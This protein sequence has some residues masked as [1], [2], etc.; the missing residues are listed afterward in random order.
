MTQPSPNPPVTPRRAPF[1]T[2]ALMSALFL[3]LLAVLAASVSTPSAWS[4]PQGAGPSSPPS[5][6]LTERRAEVSALKT[7]VSALDDQ[8]SALVEQ[9][10]QAG[11]FLS[12]AKK[13]E[14]QATFEV[15]AAKRSLAE[16][17][18]RFQNRVRQTYK[19]SPLTVLDLL[20]SSRS[21]SELVSRVRYVTG[22]LEGDRRT[23]DEVAQ[24]KSELEER[25][26]ALEAE[27]TRRETIARGIAQKRDQIEAKLAERQQDLGAARSDVA[28]KVEQQRSADLARRASARVISAA[29]QDAAQ[30]TTAADAASVTTTTTHVAR[31]TATTKQS[32]AAAP[33]TTTTAQHRTTTTAQ[34]RTSTT[35]HRKTTTTTKPTPKAVKDPAP[36]GLGDR[37]VDIGMRYLGVP[38]VWGGA[39][40]KGFDCSGLTMYVLGKVGV[41]LP[42]SSGLQFQMGTPVGRDSLRPGDLVFFGSPVHHVGI[43]VGGGEY[44]HAPYTGEVVRVSALNRSDYAGARRF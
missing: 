11:Y 32:T 43:Y 35:T 16:A 12:V 20:L 28:R 7:E 1:T 4:A 29:A 22:I 13:N 41:D 23:I 2:D 18:R 38:Y 15:V 5:V 30:E 40:T 34:H 8:I 3:V 9:Y 21:T 6:E 33:R 24:K 44:L 26:H 42:H 36:S 39:S 19:Q 27:R 31:T 14:Q 25:M 17:K 10:D 37:I